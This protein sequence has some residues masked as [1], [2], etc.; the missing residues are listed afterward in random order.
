MLV[1]IQVQGQQLTTLFNEQL[2][3][4]NQLIGSKKLESV[5]VTHEVEPGYAVSPVTKDIS[6]LLLVKVAKPLVPC[7]RLINPGVGPREFG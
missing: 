5:S 3:A 6:V 2:V 7:C 1:K 4:I